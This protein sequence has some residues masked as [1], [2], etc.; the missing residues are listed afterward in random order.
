MGNIVPRRRRH[1]NIKLCLDGISEPSMLDWTPDGRMFVLSR[2]GSIWVVDQDGNKLPDPW[3]DLRSFG[4]V[5][6]N[7]ALG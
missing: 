5:L 6:G 1:N 3:I 2:H 4:T 7:G